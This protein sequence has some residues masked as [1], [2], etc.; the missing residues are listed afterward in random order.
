MKRIIPVFLALMV[1]VPVTGVSATRDKQYQVSTSIGIGTGFPIESDA[2]E[3]NY[4]P[5]FGVVLDVAVR[6]S[7][8]EVS[9]S[10][11]YN[12]FMSNGL[13]PDDINILSIFLNLKIKPGGK[14]SVRP[15]IL[16][17]GGYFRSWIVDVK[18]VENTTGYQGGVGIELDISKKQA[19]FIDAKQVIG[20]TRE[21]SA[22]KSNTTYIGVRAGMTFLF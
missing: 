9:T 13:E 3:S 10:F 4:D 5:S 16:V 21:T 7:L 19:L 8:L 2:F 14:S 22:Q 12:F 17:G 20:R 1:L 6:R 18:I 15:Y 11:D